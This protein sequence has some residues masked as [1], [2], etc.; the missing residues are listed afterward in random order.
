MKFI[1]KVKYLMI[2][3]RITKTYLAKKVGVSFAYIWKVLKEDVS[4]PSFDHCEKMADVFELSGLERVD[5]MQSAFMGKLTEDQQ[6]FLSV[7]KSGVSDII[8]STYGPLLGEKVRVLHKQ[9]MIELVSKMDGL[10][11]DKF[12]SVVD[13]LLTFLKGVDL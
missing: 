12:D 11:E 9:K 4:V 13:T 1:D 5:F 7:Y 2:Q 10:D 8:K 3:K 6:K